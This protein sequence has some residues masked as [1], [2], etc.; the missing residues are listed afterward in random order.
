M[1]VELMA[2]VEPERAGVIL[3]DRRPHDDEAMLVAAARGGDSEAFKE[4]VERYERRIF[5]I[6]QNITQNREDA[7]DALQESFL[8]A[9]IHLESFHGDSRF[10]TWLTRIAVNQALM[11]LRRRRPNHLALDELIETE[12]DSIP[13]EIEDWGPTPEQQYSRGELQEILAGAIGRI[14]PT[15]R[16]VFQL[17]DVEEFSIEETAQVLGLSNSAVKSRLMRARLELRE[18]L[19]PYFRRNRA[20]SLKN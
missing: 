13:R 6:A 15:N 3:A 4:L 9:F 17:R 7:E 14:S 8:N 19:N 11:K 18:R 16:V 20:G 5:R 2:E 1:P 10:S 12:S